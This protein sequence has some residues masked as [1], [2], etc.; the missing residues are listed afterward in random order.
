MRTQIRGLFGDTVE[1]ASFIA[2]LDEFL[3]E[4]RDRFKIVTTLATAP[5]FRATLLDHDT[6]FQLF[7]IIQE[8]LT[9][10]GRH[11]QASAIRVALAA[12]ED[13]IAVTVE[14]NGQGFDV[15]SASESGTDHFGLRI[16]RQRARD[17]GS[18][19]RIESAPGRGT[20]VLVQLPLRARTAADHASAT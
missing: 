19:L 5:A 15:Q 9:N 10:A 12:E 11:S 18:E 7:R 2:G 13:C 20:T 14:D 16:M 8:A 4:F 6:S 1:G 17:I 3:V